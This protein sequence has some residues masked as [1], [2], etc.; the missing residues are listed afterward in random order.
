MIR[1]FARSPAPT[2]PPTA[3]T[4]LIYHGIP[5]AVNGRGDDAYAGQL[6][7][8]WDDVVF[9]A[10]LCFRGHAGAHASTRLI[11]ERARRLNPSAAFH[12]HV[13]L[14]AGDDPTEVARAASAWQAMG[15]DG[16]MLTGAVDPGELVEAVH[17]VHDAGSAVLTW[18]ADAHALCP[19]EDPRAPLGP[20]DTALL[21]S[22]VVDTDAHALTGGVDTMAGTRAAAEAARALRHRVGGGA[23]GGG[24]ARH[25]GAPREVPRALFGLVEAAALVFGLD[26]YGLCAA[27]FAGP[28]PDENVAVAHRPSPLRVDHHPE[29]PCALDAAGVEASRADLGLT[30][31]ISPG[32][33]SYRLD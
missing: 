27:N 1:L 12:G 4:F 11:V 6:F 28:G 3:R 16:V 30:V 17:A 10:G 13:D 19:T 21:R 15:A 22:W 18:D 32:S 5:Q 20:G 9:A 14:R 23:V 8:R 24:A 29:E 33:N 7:S 31:R 26:G 25:D 2:P